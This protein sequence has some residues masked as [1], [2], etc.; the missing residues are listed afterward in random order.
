[1]TVRSPAAAGV[2]DVTLST[3]ETASSGRRRY[4]LWD[5]TNSVLYAAGVLTVRA[6]EGNEP[7]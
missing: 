1:M 4:E 6:T 5:V 7:A 2:V 3:A